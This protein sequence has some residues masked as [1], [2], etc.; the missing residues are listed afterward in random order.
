M[1]PK[2]RNLTIT[3][4]TLAAASSLLLVTT[5]NKPKTLKL[6]WEHPS[7]NITFRVWAADSLT[8][9][10]KLLGETTNKFFVITNEKPSA[11][12]CVSVKE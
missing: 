12:F 11:F 10:K 8:S 2:Q 6:T 9:E 1:T 5:P 7:S 3:G 4:V